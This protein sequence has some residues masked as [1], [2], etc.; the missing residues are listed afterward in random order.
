MIIQVIQPRTWILGSPPYIFCVLLQGRLEVSHE[1]GVAKGQGR[2]LEAP[3]ATSTHTVSK[4][5]HSLS[6]LISVPLVSHLCN[7]DTCFQLIG[8][9]ED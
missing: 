3:G 4:L 1:L 8:S 2:R 7:R 6:H 5:H 9:F